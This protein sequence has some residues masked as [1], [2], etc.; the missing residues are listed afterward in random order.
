MNYSLQ[1]YAHNVVHAL[2]ETCIEYNLPHPDII[3]ESG[4]ALTAH[5]AVLITEVINTEHVIPLNKIQPPDDEDPLILHD[6]WRALENLSRK[7]ARIAIES[8]HDT[9][10]WVSEAQTMY[11]HGVITLSQKAKIEELYYAI[12]SGVRQLLNSSNRIHREILDEINEK[13]AD[14]YFCNFSLFQSLPDI[15]AID[16]VFPIVP[17]H[18]LDEEPDRRGIIQDITCDSDGRIDKY[19]DSDGIESSLPLHQKN[20]GKPYWL[21]IFLTGA[22]QEILGDMHNLFGDTCSVNVRLDKKKK[23]I[24]ENTHEGDTV[25]H[26]IQYVNYEPKQLL[27]AYQKQITQAKLK[28]TQRKEYLKDLRAGLKGYTYL[29]D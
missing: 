11:M 9:V 28:S 2:W 6:L 5:H 26:V 22:Y 16:Q 14:K 12:C 1:E 4:R 20:S 24:I 18:R 27:A 8:Y 25:E 13:L 23:Y 7:N 10:H 29:E 15:W 19:V 17:L 21:G 3:S